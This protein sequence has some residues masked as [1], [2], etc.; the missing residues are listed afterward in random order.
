MG[1][2]AMLALV[3]RGR[4]VF[5]LSGYILRLMSHM[6]IFV[7]LSA[8]KSALFNYAAPAPSSAPDSTTV[9]SNSTPQI[10]V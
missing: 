5:L 9:Y 8:T 7:P 2:A 3:V 6:S 1:A 10:S 4:G